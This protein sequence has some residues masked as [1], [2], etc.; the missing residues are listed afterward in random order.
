MNPDSREPQSPKPSTPPQTFKAPEALTPAPRIPAPTSP[1]HADR[2]T[3]PATSPKSRH[4]EVE[5]EAHERV[6]F[7]GLFRCF[8]VKRGLY[9]SGFF[10][11]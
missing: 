5:S 8:R 2:R 6:F 3:R 11:V 10:K 1:A 9:G 7:K 4:L